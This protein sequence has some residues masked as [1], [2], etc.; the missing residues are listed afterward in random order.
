ME[1]FDPS[2]AVAKIRAALDH[3]VVD[4][5]GHLVEVRPVAMEYIE[6][7]G[8]SDIARRFGE[9]Q[10]ATFLSRDWYGLS[11]AERMTR[12]THRPPFRERNAVSASSTQVRL[13][14]GDTAP[15]S[16]RA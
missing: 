4:S 6:R 13:A 16:G 7:A 14:H 15:V 2:P 9:E 8:G 1:R 12:W 5:D 11:D 3:P 10:R